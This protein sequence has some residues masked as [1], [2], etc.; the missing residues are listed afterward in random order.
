MATSQKRKFKKNFQCF[1]GE[2]KGRW[3]KGQVSKFKINLRKPYNLKFKM[4]IIDTVIFWSCDL[5]TYYCINTVKA[6]FF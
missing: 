6:V 5:Q 1:G 4:Q 3:A 2:G